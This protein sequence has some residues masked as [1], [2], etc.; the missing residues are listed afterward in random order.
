MPFPLQRTKK[1]DPRNESQVS[2]FHWLYARALTTGSLYQE[3]LA[4]KTVAGLQFEQDHSSLH[5]GLVH[6]VHKP[7]ISGHYDHL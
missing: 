5:R 4:I 7:P 1:P 3:T 2:G 6:D